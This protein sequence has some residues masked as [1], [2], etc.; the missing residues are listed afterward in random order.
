MLR[1][2]EV[3]HKASV[4]VPEFEAISRETTFAPGSGCRAGSGPAVRPP[5]FPM[6]SMITNFPRAPIAAREGLHAAFG[7]PIL[8][9]GDVLGV[10]ECFQP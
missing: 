4:E 3:W 8:L 6:S 2:V 5:T 10:I 1:C 9:G 7:F